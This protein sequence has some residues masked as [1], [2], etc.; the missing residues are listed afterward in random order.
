[1]AFPVQTQEAQASLLEKIGRQ[2]NINGAKLASIMKH[3]CFKQPK[4]MDGQQAEVSD[5]Q[6]AALL[7]VADKYGLNPFTKEIYAFPDKQ[8]GIV[9]VVGVDGWIR[10]AQENPN[11]DGFDVCASDDVVQ[12]DPESGK[13]EGKT[14]PEWMQVTVYKKN[15]SHPTVIREYLD[16]CYRPPFKARDYSV[17][18]PWQSHP[19]RMLRHKAMIQAFRAAF[20]FS[21]IY[22]DDEAERIASARLV[23]MNEGLA[24]ALEVERTD[25]L[26]AMER[27]VQKT[28]DA[29]VTASGI[30]YDTVSAFVGA[31]AA[32]QHVEEEAVMRKALDDFPSF[33]RYYRA[34]LNTQ[35]PAAA[36]PRGRRKAEPE[37]AQ[38]AQAEKIDQET[39]EVTEE[40]NQTASA[41][42]EISPTVDCPDRDGIP[43]S[44][45]YCAKCSRREG[46]P[47]WD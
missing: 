47:A 30:D 43:T 25:E 38:E 11:F 16:E 33:L 2:Y 46:C 32:K 15:Q 39:G 5:E 45:Q 23:A 18:G 4:A 10:I 29:Q 22:E 27:N 41:A 13:N 44:A 31:W 34:W 26:P 21:G 20:G 3:T 8:N 37:P 17:T 9:P 24:K 1:M 42:A 7:V 36:K 14:C 19:K 12:V 6:L 28:F 35:Q 40:P